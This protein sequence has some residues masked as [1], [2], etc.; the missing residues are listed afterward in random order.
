MARL[1]EVSEQPIHS[2]W[3]IFRRLLLVIT[4]IAAL[5][6]PALFGAEEATGAA[7]PHEAAAHG[8]AHKAE[9]HSLPKPAPALFYGIG[10]NAETGKVGP[11]AITNSMVVMF[12]VAAG[13]ILVAQLATRKA[14]MIPSGLQN[15]V[16]WL[17]ESLYDFFEGVLGEHMVK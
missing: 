1:L 7:A 14:K 6:F 15:F 2:F 3:M 16:E 5:P 10:G 11:L 12:I 17:V 8:E 13:I 4:L 9:H